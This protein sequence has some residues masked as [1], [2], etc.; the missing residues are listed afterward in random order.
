M[1]SLNRCST[2]LANANPFLERLYFFRM[3]GVFFKVPKGGNHGC[4]GAPVGWPPVPG[5]GGRGTTLVDV[6]LPGYEPLRTEGKHNVSGGFGHML[7]YQANATFN[8]L[9]PP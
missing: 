5:G 1:S 8:E 6:D 3:G 2:S 7:A 4:A 9:A